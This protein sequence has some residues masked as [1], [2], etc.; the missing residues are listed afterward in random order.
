MTY[1]RSLYYTPQLVELA[2][3][4][5][6]RADKRE[7]ERIDWESVEVPEDVTC[8]RWR[9]SFHIDLWFMAELEAPM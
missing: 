5:P 2:S 3:R 9:K 4:A 8:W 1:E 7:E 6:S